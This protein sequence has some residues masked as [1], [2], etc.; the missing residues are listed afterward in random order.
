M[1]ST[2]FSLNHRGQK[3]TTTPL[4]V[5]ASSVFTLDSPQIHTRVWLVRVCLWSLDPE[6]CRIF[7]STSS[8]RERKNI[9]GSSLGHTHTNTQETVW[10]HSRLC[11]CMNLQMI[12]S[13]QHLTEISEHKRVCIDL[14]QTEALT[15][16]R[17]VMAD[18]T[19]N[20]AAW[21]SHTNPH[22]HTHTHTSAS[23]TRD[24]TAG[25]TDAENH[26]IPHYA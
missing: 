10:S 2:A 11:V 14:K 21:R 15:V 22:A 8:V 25:Q 23:L 26:E 7:R 9:V 20:G 5:G 12:S 19:T 1:Y 6:L 16:G 3:T 24:R 4:F 13:L 17:A 18:K